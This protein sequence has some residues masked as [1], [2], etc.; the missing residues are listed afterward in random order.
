MQGVVVTAEMLSRAG[1]PDVWQWEDEA[2]LRAFY[3]LW[4]I[5][6]YP[7]EGDDEWITWIVNRAYGFDYPTKTP[8]SPGKAMGWTD[9]THAPGLG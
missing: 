8:V 7:P 5:C 3:W 9:W 2:I 6:E 4:D 1:Y